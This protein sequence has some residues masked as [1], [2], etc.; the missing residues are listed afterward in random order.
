MERI[1]WPDGKQFAFTIVDDTDL[2]TVK[3]VEQIY[4]HLQKAGMRTTKTVWAYPSRDTFHGDCLTANPEYRKFV[5]ELDRK[6]FEIAYHGAGSGAFTR[7]ETRAGLEEVR[8]TVGHYPR[9]HV[10]HANNPDG[11]YWGA[12]RLT[13]FV[14]FFFG[15][16]RRLRGRTPSTYGHVPDSEY[17][18]GDICKQNIDYIRNHT[19]RG[20]NILRY[21]KVMP[22]WDQKKQAYSNYWY[23]ASDGMEYSAFKRLVTRERVDKLVKE[24]GLAVIYVH[25]AFGFTDDDGTPKQDFLDRIDYVASQNGWFAPVSEV[26]DFLKMQKGRGK[27]VGYFAKFRMDLTWM[28]EALWTKLLG[29]K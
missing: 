18:W 27:K 26:L 6:G 3:N 22:Y 12:S 25:F 10:N 24:G 21:D 9:M 7:E 11:I 23:S 8:K 2:S 5:Q 17:F 13:P 28:A 1:H 16:Y 14:A 19:F 4:A 29:Q 20:L 15:L